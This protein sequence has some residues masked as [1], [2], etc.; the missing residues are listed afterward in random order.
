MKRKVSPDVQNCDKCRSS[1]E[2]SHLKEFIDNLPYIIMVIMGSAILLWG[3]RFLLVAWISAGAYF[4]YGLVGALW[5]I[6]F[7]CPYCHFYDTRL[8]PCGYGQ[9]SAR[10]VARKDGDRFRE[11]FKK[12]IPVI[13]SLWF[14]P[15]IAGIIFLVCHFSRSLLVLLIIFC[16]NSFLILPLVSRKYG[17]ANCPQ[18]DSCPW[19]G[20]KQNNQI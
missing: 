4:I 15:F 13:V 14:I 12:H 17:C 16:I 11:K 9:I 8:C 3:L 2:Y 7:V 19:M 1:A 5:I 6:I 20:N 10:L 18:A